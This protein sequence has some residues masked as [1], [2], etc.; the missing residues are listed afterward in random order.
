MLTVRYHVGDEPMTTETAHR[1]LMLT[2]QIAAAYV[3][4]NAVDATAVP[5][6]VRDIQRSR[7]DLKPGGV[8][9]H[10]K[11]RPAE[12]RPIGQPAVDIR[13]SVFADRLVCLEDGARVSMLKC[14]LRTAYGLTPDQYRAKWDLPAT[15]PM[16]APMV[17]PVR[18]R[19]RRAGL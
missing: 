6:L 14:H 2:T 9:E 5:G 19:P 17:A 10:P 1:L 13:K 11:P 12:H 4:A 7:A 16:V 8:V 3:S 18:S 15:Y